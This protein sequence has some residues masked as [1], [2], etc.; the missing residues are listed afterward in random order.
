M[1]IEVSEGTYK[2]ILYNFTEENG[3]VKV[4]PQDYTTTSSYREP[5]Y[6]TDSSYADAS[7]YNNVGITESS[8]Q[9]EFNTMV[10]RVASKG[11]FWVGR[12][13]TSSMV[14]DNTQDTTNRVTVIRGTTEGINNVNWYRMYAQQK[15]YKTNALTE[16]ANVTSSMIWGSQWDQIMIWM[17]SVPSKYTDSTYTGK[18]YVTN[19]VSMGNFGTISGVDDGWS[20]TSLLAP[21]GNS[22]NYKVKNVFDL[23]GNLYDRTLEADYTDSRVSRGGNYY[24]TSSSNSRADSRDYNGPNDSDS[25]LGSRATLY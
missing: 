15:A 19:A 24:N 9:S 13:E 7:S 23:A 25:F 17:K 11:G 22:E 12:Y 16:S 4:T 2:G 10:T 14:E 21:T 18:F 5:A 8:L 3:A 20:S 1:A 6:L